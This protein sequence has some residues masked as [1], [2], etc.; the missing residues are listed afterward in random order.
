[1]YR[2]LEGNDLLPEEQKGCRRNSKG[3]ADLLFID[4]MLLEEVKFRKRNLAMGWIDYCKAYDMLP[5]S[6]IIKCLVILG[7]NGKVQNLLQESMMKW[8]VELTCGK[9]ELGEVSIKR[10]VFQG[11]AL[12]PILFM[13][14]LIPLTS[15]LRNVKAGY[16]FVTNKE[17]INQLLFMDDLKP[18]A[19][20]EKIWSHLIQI[21]R[22]FSCHDTHFLGYFVEFYDSPS[23][24]IHRDIFFL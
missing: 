9:E 18:Y 15:V 3:T 4:K 21:V 20:S 19:K 10:G 1:M 16:S 14:A 13:I 22:I 6:W 2:F 11:D 8:K 12:S 5:H 23:M 17:K 7:I 24:L